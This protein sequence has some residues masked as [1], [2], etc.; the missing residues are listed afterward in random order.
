[1]AGEWMNYGAV[2]MKAEVADEVICCGFLTSARNAT[3]ALFVCF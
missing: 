3:A 1:M 2:G